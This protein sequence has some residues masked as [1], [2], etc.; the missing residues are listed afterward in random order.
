LN[1][2]SAF[3]LVQDELFLV[4]EKMRVQAEQ[5]FP[6][7][8]AALHHLLKS[9]GKRIR[10]TLTLLVGRMLKGSQEQLVTLG[11]AIEM[12]H[13]A[14]LV[15]DDLIDGAL[16]RRGIPTLNSQWSPAATVLTGD[17]LF[18]KAARL[19]AEADSLPAMRLFAETLAVIVNGEITQ[20]FSKRIYALNG[21]FQKENQRSYYER[22]HAK[23]ASLF[24]TSTAVAAL[25]SPVGEDVVQDASA[26]GYNVGMAFQIIDDV[27]DFTGDPEK[28]GKP[29][30]SDLRQG[31]ITLPTIHY[32]DAL[33]NKQARE[34][35]L[36][37]VENQENGDLDGVI[38]SICESPAIERS[39]VDAR[40]F[41]Q[42][43]VQNLS[44]MPG[45]PERK[46]LEDLTTYIVDRTI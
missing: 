40:D 8:R 10:P 19:A 42:K 37:M 38:D 12:L 25:V 36:K 7:L 16:L 26:Y 27:L 31:I 23:T 14:T 34:T 6:D 29:V 11:A 2:H 4:E 44:R 32:L 9:G 28:V 5:D 39:I 20:M 33:G 17:Y 45:C 46:V 41:A 18:A 30:G 15:H 22:I 1:W 43:A 35:V 3:D 13:T 21:D 24:R